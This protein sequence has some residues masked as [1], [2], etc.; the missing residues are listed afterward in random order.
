MDA[1]ECGRKVPAIVIAPKVKSGSSRESSKILSVL[2][3]V[4]ENYKIDTNRVAI[5]IWL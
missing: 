4:Q 1:V 2:E 3:Y 5:S